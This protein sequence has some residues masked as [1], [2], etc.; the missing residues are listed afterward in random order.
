MNN[1][2]KWIRRE[3]MC[4]EMKCKT[5]LLIRLEDNDGVVAVNGIMCDC[6][7]LAAH[8]GEDCEWSCWARASRGE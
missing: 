4:R 5:R 3:V 2:K 7:A 6:P 1:V 8:G